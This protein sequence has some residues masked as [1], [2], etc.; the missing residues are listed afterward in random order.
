MSICQAYLM[1]HTHSGHNVVSTHLEYVEL[2]GRDDEWLLYDTD[3][4]VWIITV[5]KVLSEATALGSD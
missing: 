2:R 1:R 5:V 4:R 3:Y